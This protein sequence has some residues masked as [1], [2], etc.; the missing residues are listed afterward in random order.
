MTNTIKTLFV[1]TATQK[2][3]AELVLSNI[4][5]PNG[6]WAAKGAEWDG[7]IVKVADDISK[8]GNDFDPKKVVFDLCETSFV[9][10]LLPHAQNFVGA[11]YTRKAFR[12]DLW[13]IMW[14]MRS[15]VNGPKAYSRIGVWS[16]SERKGRPSADMIAALAK[17]KKSR[18]T[19]KA[20]PAPAPEPVAA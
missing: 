18:S 3:V 20:T 2:I 13:D 1:R 12:K 17:P 10:A 4:V 11:D 15:P 5:D 7:T 8:V 6:W 19:K 16:G 9:D 14:D